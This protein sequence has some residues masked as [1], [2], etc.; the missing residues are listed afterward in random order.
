MELECGLVGQAKIG[1]PNKKNT[2]TYRSA[3]GNGEG[4]GESR[5][6]LRVEY[7]KKTIG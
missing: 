4:M 7:V 5:S 6:L 3:K 2:N 1:V